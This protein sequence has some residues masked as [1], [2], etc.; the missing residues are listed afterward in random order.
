VKDGNLRGLAEF[1]RVKYFIQA[2]GPAAGAGHAGSY[3]GENAGQQCGHSKLCCD[4]LRN[5]A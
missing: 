3:A 4:L 1:G 5:I 2:G